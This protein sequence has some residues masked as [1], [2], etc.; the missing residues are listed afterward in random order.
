MVPNDQMILKTRIENSGMSYKQLE[1]MTGIPKSAIQRYATGTTEKIPADRLRMLLSVLAA[2]QTDQQIE[3]P[4][5]LRESD[6]GTMT[7]RIKAIRKAQ[8]LSAEQIAGAIGVSPATVYR[9]ESGD[10]DPGGSQLCRMADVLGV[11]TDELLGRPDHLNDQR[12]GESMKE[13]TLNDLLEISEA[14]NLRLRVP[15]TARL[16]ATVDVDTTDSAAL[17]DIV[18]VYGTMLVKSIDARSVHTSLLLVELKR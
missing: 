14:E 10:Y 3:R 18:D 2:S 4:N 7:N 13:I 11:T 5:D 9:W 6:E 8:G 16:M 1:E 12:G 17:T 15:M